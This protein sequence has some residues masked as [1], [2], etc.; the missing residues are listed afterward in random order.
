MGREAQVDW[1]EAYADLAGER[2]KLQVFGCAAWQR[3]GVPL[4]LPA[5]DSTAFLEAHELAFAIL[6]CLRKLPMTTHLGSKA[7]SARSRRE[8]TARFVAFR[9]HWRYEA[10]FARRPTTGEGRIEGKRAT[11]GATT[12]CRCR[13][14]G[15]CGAEP[16]LRD[17]C[18]RMNSV[19]SQD[20]SRQW[21]GM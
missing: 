19:G 15:Y 16:E 8:E 1:Y 5:C 20:A 14:R 6:A 17:A 9:S 7:D 2:V 12:G 21:A 13:Q 18:S 11:F 10:E 4:R 3:R